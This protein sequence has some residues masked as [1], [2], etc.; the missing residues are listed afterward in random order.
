L[1]QLSARAERI[2]A[3]RVIESRDVESELLG[4]PVREL[5]FEVEQSLKGDAGAGASLKIRM[6]DTVA[7]MPRFEPGEEVLLFLHAPSALGLTSPV[8]L[9][10][11]KIDLVRD[12]HGQRVAVSR[13]S[14]GS[15]LRDVSPETLSVLGAGAQRALDADKLFDT[16]RRLV[17]TERLERGEVR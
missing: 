10:Q 9:G 5:T 3:A 12:K 6:L 7:G 11:G 14:A 2:V 8:G 17:E 13:G 16:I 4:H 15:L 1:E